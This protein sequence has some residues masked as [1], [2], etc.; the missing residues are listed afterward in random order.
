MKTEKKNMVAA[1]PHGKNTWFF[2]KPKRMANAERIDK[3]EHE[4]GIGLVI[5]II[6]MAF[7]MTIGVGLV[8]VTSTGRE[9]AGNYR[10]HQQAFNAAEAGF[11]DAWTFLSSQFSSDAWTS[12]DGHTMTEPAGIDLPSD[13]NYFRK[14]TDEELL[15]LIDTDGD[16]YANSTNVIYFNKVY[17]AASGGGLDQNYTYTAFLIDDEA[18][19]ASADPTDAIMVC[20]GCVNRGGTLVTTRLEIELVLDDE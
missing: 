20:I 2:D 8:T 15:A 13:A 18:G 14:K 3:K 7:L 11:D 6:I 16:G 19:G 1:R 10:F 12:F 4:R 9:V 5:V 17:V